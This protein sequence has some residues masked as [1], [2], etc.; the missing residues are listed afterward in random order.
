M[1]ISVNGKNAASTERYSNETISRGPVPQSMVQMIDEN[2]PEQKNYLI[3]IVGTDENH[4]D[5]KDWEFITG[6]RAAYDY[7]KG[8]AE[9]ID[10]FESKIVVETAA[11]STAK[12]VLEF[13]RYVLDNG[14]I[15]DPGFDI[16]D[17]VTGDE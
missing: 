12:T 6:R 7:I 1:D 2:D 3:L 13:M 15:E 11:V 10:L 17:Y 8:M 14:L 9:N 4:N 16:M 5:F